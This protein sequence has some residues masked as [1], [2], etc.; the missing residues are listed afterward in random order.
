MFDDAALMCEGITWD[1]VANAVPPIRAAGGVRAFV[2]SRSS[3]ADTTFNDEGEDAAGYIY[4]L[5]LY[6]FLALFLHLL[7]SLLGLSLR[8]S[9][10][11]STTLPHR[12]Y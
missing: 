3:V 10:H 1:L 6:L 2:G 8:P 12:S 9:L 7:S 11:P 4:I 5:S